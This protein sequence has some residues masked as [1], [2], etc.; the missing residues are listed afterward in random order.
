MF[1]LISGET[2]YE[3][4]YEKKHNSNKIMWQVRCTLIGKQIM[5]WWGNGCC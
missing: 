2:S 3:S 4:W 5:N 1:T